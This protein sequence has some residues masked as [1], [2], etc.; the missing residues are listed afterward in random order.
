MREKPSLADDDAL[1]PEEEGSLVCALDD[2][3]GIIWSL[4]APKLEI[5]PQVEVSVDST[6]LEP[7]Q[8]FTLTMQE[9]LPDDVHLLLEVVKGRFCKV[10]L[11]FAGDER[12]VGK[13]D[14]N[15]QRS[16]LNRSTWERIR[17]KMPPLLQ[18][19][20]EARRMI[21][22]SGA[23]LTMY[24]E[25]RRCPIVLNG[26]QYFANMVLAKLGPTLS[27]YLCMDFLLV[28]GAKIDLEK[29]HLHLSAMQ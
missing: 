15:T 19:S 3:Y 23:A 8:I 13:L 25:L 10:N 16:L 26:C 18:P 29:D 21:G 17:T 28:Y 5:L 2:K 22:A 9:R 14:T 1:T 4:S 6:V 7:M 27:A 12:V 24:G 11:E 20:Q